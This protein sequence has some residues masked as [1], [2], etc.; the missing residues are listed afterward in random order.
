[1][2]GQEISFERLTDWTEGRLPEGEA[3]EV[4]EGVATADE[5]TRRDAEWLRAFVGASEELVL[6]SPPPEVRGELMRR[7]EA[8][9][10]P[11]A[12]TSVGEERRG[13]G[14]FQRLV[15]SLSFDSGMQPAFGV[16]SAGGQ[17]G[18]RQFIYSTDVADIALNFRRRPGEG[19]LDLD[20]QIFPA[21]EGTE[22][23]DF[24]VQLLGNGATEVGTATTDDLGEFS[25]ESVPTGEYQIIVSGERVEILI[26]P[27]ELRL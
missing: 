12:G 26:T 3:R 2:P 27:V 16:R 8:H 23:S 18:Q 25:F 17:E 15:A 10:R 22:P 11:E 6:A 13:P 7:F 4:A 1:M 24:A 9:F 21:R 14:L 5:E 19:G 20:G